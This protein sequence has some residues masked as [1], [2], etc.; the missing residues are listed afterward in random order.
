MYV[1]SLVGHMCLVCRMTLLVDGLSSV[2]DIKNGF[3]PADKFG[4]PVFPVY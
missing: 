3:F 2:V 4:V 1:G